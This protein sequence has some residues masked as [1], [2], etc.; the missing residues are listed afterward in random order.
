MLRFWSK[1][2]DS[3]PHANPGRLTGDADRDVERGTDPD[4]DQFRL[5]PF[6]EQLCAGASIWLVRRDRPA[7]VCTALSNLV[8]RDDRPGRLMSREGLEQWGM[9][10]T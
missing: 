9:L 8:T 3:K 2:D 10:W 7:R 4:A 6:Q 5:S 1:R